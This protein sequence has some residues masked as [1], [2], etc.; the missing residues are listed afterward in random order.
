MEPKKQSDRKVRVN[1]KIPLI[2]AGICLVLYFPSFGLV[3]ALYWKND[4]YMYTNKTWRYNLAFK[5][6]CLLHQNTSILDEYV[7]LWVRVVHPGSKT[8][9]PKEIKRLL[10]GKW[11]F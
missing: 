2:A 7:A 9:D 5:P 3:S 10:S 8:F 6:F 4:W 1:R 11:H